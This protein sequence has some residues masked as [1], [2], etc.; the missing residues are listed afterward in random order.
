MPK[1]A[2]TA[3]TLAQQAKPDHLL[4]HGRWTPAAIAHEIQ[5]IRTTRLHRN[6]IQLPSR[7]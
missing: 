1:E 4:S 3:R 6:D 7:E 5:K 2:Y